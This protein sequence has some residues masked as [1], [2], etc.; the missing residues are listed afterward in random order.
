MS[1]ISSSPAPSREQLLSRQELIISKT[2]QKGIVTY[3][4]RT[5]MKISGYREDQIIGCPHNF[6]RHPDMPRTCFK[7]L[8]DTIQTGNEFFAYV[9]NRCNNGDFYWVLANITPD[10]SASGELL[11][12]YSVRRAPTREAINKIIPIYQKMLEIEQQ[13]SADTGMQRAQHYLI[14][15]IAHTN[16]SYQEFILNLDQGEC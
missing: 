12:Y 8:W 9:I 13:S 6:I 15:Q 1:N 16:L 7:L 11:G 14:E 2:D 5:F 4:N 10:Y 3:A